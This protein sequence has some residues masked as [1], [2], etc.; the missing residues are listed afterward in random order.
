MADSFAGLPSSRYR[1]ASTVNS[2]DPAQDTASR[3]FG[4]RLILKKSRYRP[5]TASAFRYSK[6][7]VFDTARIISIPKEPARGG[8]P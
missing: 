3:V 7:N 6:R 8:P 5:Q 2:G 1:S 4:N